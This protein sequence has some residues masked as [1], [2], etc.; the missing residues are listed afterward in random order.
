MSGANGA[1][2]DQHR[3]CP[4][5]RW[6][7]VG[8]YLLN[9]E[10]VYSPAGAG[11]TYV[12]L[13]PPLPTEPLPPPLPTEPLPTAPLPPPLPTAPL[14]PE[15]TPPRPPPSGAPPGGAPA[16]AAAAAAAAAAADDHDLAIRGR[17][18]AGLELDD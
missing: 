12:P 10:T 1:E 18:A 9:S 16:D 5:G 8:L 3:A 4:G 11:P 6:P 14:P 17:C 7:G 15:P 13:P 2:T